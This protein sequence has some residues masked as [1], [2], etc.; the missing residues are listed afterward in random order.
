[1]QFELERYIS[2][3]FCRYI[4]ADTTRLR[5]RYIVEE[6]KPGKLERRV[7]EICH[8]W[9]RSSPNSKGVVYCRSRAQCETL[10]DELGCAYYH[11]EA[12]GREERIADWARE[13]CTINF[14]LDK[15]ID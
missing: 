14:L 13:V 9:T 4:R 15:S 7:V 8:S 5:T 3:E 6:Y 10:A 12:D 2:I 11:A 1:M